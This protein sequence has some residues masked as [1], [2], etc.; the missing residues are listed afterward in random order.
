MIAY[1]DLSD[2]EKERLAAAYEAGFAAAAYRPSRIPDHLRLL[3][4][5]VMDDW[6]RRLDANKAAY[7]EPQSP[8]WLTAY[9]ERVEALGDC[10]P[11]AGWESAPLSGVT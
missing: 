7:A 1:A 3:I 10:V 6:F 8:D 4:A 11:P 2:D 9:A 5:H